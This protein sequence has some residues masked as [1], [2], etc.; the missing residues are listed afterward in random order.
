V[1]TLG[2]DLASQP[3]STALCTISWD[4]T[5]VIDVPTPS[6]S[7]DVLARRIESSDKVG[8]DVPLGW[9]TPFVEALMD[10]HEGRRWKAGHGNAVQ[11]RRT[12]AVV[13]HM[14]GKRPLSVS[15]DKIAIPAMRAANLLSA[16]DSEMDRSGKGK[17]VEVYPAAA[18]RCWSFPSEG[19]KGRGGRSVR[20]KLAQSFFDRMHRWVEITPEVHASC[21]ESDHAFDALVA[22]LVARAAHLGLVQPLPEEAAEAARREGWIALPLADSLDQLA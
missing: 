1:I 16:I 9:P 7:D 17:V 6:A 5:V 18:L 20:E 2:V 10:Y 14:T 15:S 22:A 4:R 13:R 12:D 8:I 11:L 19:Y 3:T 21:L